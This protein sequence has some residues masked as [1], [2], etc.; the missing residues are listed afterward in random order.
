MT[1]A[2]LV[3][4]GLSKSFQKEDQLITVLKDVSLEI[5]YKES[6]ASVGASGSG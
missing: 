3:L 1:K 6:V 2:L 5:D 4:Q